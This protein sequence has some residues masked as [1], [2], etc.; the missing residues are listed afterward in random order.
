VAIVYEM[1][2]MW[3]ILHPA[4]PPRGWV[5]ESF[6]LRLQLGRVC[7]SRT[8]YI[9]RRHYLRIRLGYRKSIHAMFEIA[10]M[11]LGGAVNG[12]S[13]HA[14]N[15]FFEEQRVEINGHVKPPHTRTPTQ[16]QLIMVY[17]STKPPDRS[18]PYATIKTNTEHPTNINAMCN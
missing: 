12:S 2:A 10:L 18:R 13:H 6:R 17:R 7:E 16:P 4:R 15:T 9:L 5:I 3:M 14:K 1:C 8:T 11:F